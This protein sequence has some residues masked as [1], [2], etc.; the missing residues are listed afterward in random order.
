MSNEEKSVEIVTINDPEGF[1]PDTMFKLMAIFED[2]DAGVS[3]AADLR[4]N[5]FE[6]ADIQLFCGVPGE[7][8]FDFDG[9]SH[10]P[11]A[12][13]MRAFRSITFDRVVMER[14]Q[15]ALREGHCL[16]MLHIDKAKEKEAAAAVMLKYNATQVE[17]FGL[18]ATHRFDDST[19]H[20]VAG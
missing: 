19:T 16:I 10:G 11:L 20:P 7:Q 5:G 4:L 3:A 2:P 14:Y 15:Q 6:D 1:T 18:L 8:T 13:F 12:T 9:D 17:Y